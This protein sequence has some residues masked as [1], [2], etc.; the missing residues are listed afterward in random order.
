LRKAETTT[1]MISIAAVAVAAMGAAT[2][3]ANAISRIE[4]TKTDCQDIR[5]ALIAEGAAILRHTSKNGLPIYDRYVSSSL[6]CRR[7]E[8]GVW[9]SVP[10]RDT[11]TCRVI[12]CDP[13]IGDDD[14]DLTRFRP[15][16]RITQ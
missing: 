4:T 10:A 7:S 8:V 3:N 11:K 2:M 13:N 5:G 16:L 12:A 6:M 14:D 9:A 15:L 1:R